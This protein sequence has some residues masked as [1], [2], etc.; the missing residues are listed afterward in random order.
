MADER[1]P[2]A[3]LETVTLE[4]SDEPVRVTLEERD[5]NRVLLRQIDPGEPVPPR[6]PLYEG[7]ELVVMQAISHVGL[8]TTSEPGDM[9]GFVVSMR[10][11]PVRREG[12][13]VFCRT[14]RVG[15]A[16]DGSRVHVRPGDSV[17]F[18]AGGVTVE[19]D[20]IDSLEKPTASGYVPLMP[21]LW[22]WLVVG[23]ADA[24]EAK[25]ARTRYLLAAARRLDA[26]NS[27]MMQIEDRRAELAGDPRFGP[28]IRRALFDLIAHV[29]MAVVALGRVVD[30][31]MAAQERIGIASPVPKSITDAADPIRA[32]RNAYEH[33]EDRALGYVQGKPHPDALTIFD[34]RELIK[35]DRIVYGAQQLELSS[36][37]PALLREARDFIKTAAGGG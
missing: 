13:V 31:I 8:H 5:G 2:R 27:L 20:H 1:E 14:L 28:A 34:H 32:I 15:E 35:N 25:A 9:T 18:E 3:W 30:M 29:E 33:V 26:A 6:V 19:L 16:D 7:D 11:I 21:V 12:N 17:T 22:A 37:L 4:G 24:D 10:A 36:Q 23:A